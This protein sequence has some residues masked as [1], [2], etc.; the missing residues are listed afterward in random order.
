MQS[1]PCR[2]LAT[3]NNLVFHVHNRAIRRHQLFFHDGDY[4]AFERVLAE[5]L[6]RVAVPLLTYCVMLREIQQAVRRALPIGDPEWSK[7]HRV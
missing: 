2:A 4:E 1:M 3:A 6:T 5:A 7:R